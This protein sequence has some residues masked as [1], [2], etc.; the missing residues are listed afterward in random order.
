MTKAHTS[1]RCA[2]QAVL[3]AGALTSSFSAIAQDVVAAPDP[4]AAS[5]PE[6]D[7]T[8]TGAAEQGTDELETIVVT[9]NKREQSL[10]DVAL[11]VSAFGAADL[12]QQFVTSATDLRLVSPSINF[13]SSSNVRGEGF[14]MRGVGTSAFADSVEQ[15]VGFVVDGVAMA[16]SGMVS[17]GM[18]DVARVEVLR[19]PQG[20][21]F[22]K[23]ASAGLV[24]V[25]TNR[26]ELGVL[27]AQA[28]VSYA[29]P[30]DEVKT[31]FTA[32]AGIGDSSA[33][34][35]SYAS[36][37]ADG[38]V[39]DVYNGRWVNDRDEQLVRAKYLFEPSDQFSAYL[40]GDWGRTR[41]ECCAYTAYAASPTSRFGKLNA[42]AGIVP[43]PTNEKMA[44]DANFF[45]HSDTYGG[46]LEL[47]YDFGWA[48]LTSITA[49]RSW[50]LNDNND[51]DIL[52]I[53]FYNTNTGMSDLHQTT[54][55]LR[56]TSPGG[57]RL[58]W[59]AGLYYFDSGIESSNDQT[60]NLG[61]A[62]P[63]GLT[64]GTLRATD[65]DSTS[66]AAF[67]QASYQ[68]TDRFTLTAGTRYTSDEVEV[69]YL[70]SKTT[71]IAV[72]GVYYGPSYGKADATNWSWRLTGQFDFSDDHMVYLTTAR[73][74]KGPALGTQGVTTPTLPVIDPEIPTTYEGGLRSRFAGGTLQVNAA[75]F[76]TVFEDFQAQTYDPSI[77]PPTFRITN[78]GELDT[79][80]LELE[81]TS[82]PFDGLRLNGSLAYVDATYTEYKDIPCY[83]GQSPILPYGT[84]RTSPRQC[85]RASASPTAPGLTYGTGNPLVNSP[86]LTWNVGARYDM[87]V[88][89]HDAFFQLN[90]IWRDENPFSAAGDPAMVLDSY[91]VLNGSVGFRAGS[92]R[93]DVT[94]FGRNLT[95][96]VYS[97]RLLEYPVPLGAGLRPEPGSYV[98][99]TS[100]YSR[101]TLGVE[102]T[103]RFGD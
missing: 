65:T 51:P 26:P 1:V 77:Q 76:K 52:P 35:I 100:P 81:V 18:I 41:A 63:G 47:N 57:D 9:A 42:A 88:G 82:L 40:I 16:R 12:Q 15:S 19:G 45:Q 27:G 72:P 71:A 68:L 94:L 60:G 84:A 36:T 58:E 90:F 78:A 96:E 43:G 3:F 80:G 50:E 5:T 49:Y 14:Q 2:V 79:Q 70:A 30:L 46:S 32:N 11:A 37:Q 54:Q 67:G 64:A 85:I 55:E 103:M 99:F 59:V 95:D 48:T 22:G 8:Q 56:L 66:W 102:L 69:H 101:R 29:D 17:G 73:G 33:V 28:T 91:G 21:L 39:H 20:M 97:E 6:S 86:E 25:I 4:A 92:G 31:E 10:Q 24:H 87:P 7:A 53:N 75:I 93:W 62:V 98:H 61:G 34:R 44:A 83:T 74:Y 13:T 23:N 89:E 38:Y